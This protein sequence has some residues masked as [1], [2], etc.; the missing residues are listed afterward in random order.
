MERKVANIPSLAPQFERELN[1]REWGHLEIYPSPTN[2][3]IDKEFY[4]NAKALGGEDETYIS[5]V[6]GK[7]I[8]FDADTINCFLGID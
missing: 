8:A 5:Y 6:R 4:T 2:I 7:R 1:N 3:D